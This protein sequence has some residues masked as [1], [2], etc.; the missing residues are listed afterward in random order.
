MYCL[1]SSCSTYTRWPVPP[2]PRGVGGLGAAVGRSRRRTMASGPLRES[3]KGL[4]RGR[5][6]RPRGES[7]RS[8]CL[9]PVEPIRPARSL[10][11]VHRPL[12]GNQP[13]PSSCLSE[14]LRALVRPGDAF[15]ADLGPIPLFHVK[16]GHSSN[17]GNGVRTA[18]MRNVRH[19]QEDVPASVCAHASA[20]TKALILLPTEFRHRA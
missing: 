16:P 8:R 15:T 19:E 7:A 11:S 3:R 5:R 10:P 2:H 13:A 20:L 17:S 1:R 12:Q 4:G 18:P 14:C 9:G 6:G